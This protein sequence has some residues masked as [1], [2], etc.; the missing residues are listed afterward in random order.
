[1]NIGSKLLWLT[2]IIVLTFLYTNPL[3]T[4][5]LALVT[6]FVGLVIGMPLKRV[7]RILG[8]L[9][10]VILSI[11][12]FTGFAP[13]FT[14]G[15]L[16]TS[17]VLVDVLGLKFTLGGVLVGVT[18]VFRLLIMVL[19]TSIMTL[20]T[21]LEDL[22]Q[23]LVKLK[24][25]YEL[26][27]ALMTGI[28]FV[29]TLEKEVSMVLDAQRARGAELEATK[30]LVQRVKSYVP[31]MVP[32]LVGGIRRSDNLGMAMLARGFGATKKRTTLRKLAIRRIDYVALPLF[33]SIFVAGV[34]LWTLGY[35]LL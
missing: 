11:I 7:W 4:G 19:A 25:P 27:F 35:G 6:F 5:A 1:M 15:E 8:P 17:V 10:P 2:M 28:R 29:P 23:F 33:A 31:V 32:M 12:F 14:V 22:I 3:Y 13:P 34:A 21:P 26:A 30:G 24:L 18:L 20:T 9:L 16:Y